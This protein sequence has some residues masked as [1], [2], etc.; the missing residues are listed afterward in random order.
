MFNALTAIFE[1]IQQAFVVSPAR[2]Y[3]RPS[4]DGFRRDAANL[5]QDVGKVGAALRKTTKQVSTAG[6][7]PG[8]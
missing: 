6:T 5:A 3:I 7:V 8:S 1:G 4:A 2:S